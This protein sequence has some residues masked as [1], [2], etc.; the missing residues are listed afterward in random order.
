MFRQARRV[1][2]LAAVVAASAAVFGGV[3]QAKGDP[4]NHGGE[5][6]KPGT[7]KSVCTMVTT[8]D[9]GMAQCWSESGQPGA[10]GQAADY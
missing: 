5:P 10:A 7:A 1:T 9:Y 8:R 2:A 6:G 4:R 3:A